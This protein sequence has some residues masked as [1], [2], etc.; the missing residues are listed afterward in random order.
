MLADKYPGPRRDGFTPRRSARI[1]KSGPD[2]A[3]IQTKKGGKP[4]RY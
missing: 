2:V 3:T 1:K 4:S